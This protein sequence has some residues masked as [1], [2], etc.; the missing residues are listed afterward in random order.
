MILHRLCPVRPLS[1]DRSAAADLSDPDDG[2]VGEAIASRDVGD[3]GELRVDDAEG[4][5]GPEIAQAPRGMPS[6]SRPSPDEVAKHFLT[7]LPYRSWCKWCVAAKRANSAHVAL[8]GHSREVPLLVADYC[9]LRDSR[10]DDLLTC[11]VARLYP[12]RA[13]LAV[14]CDVKG[15]DDY[16]VNRLTEFL[17]NA[18]ITRMV[19]MSDQETA[20]GAM[21]EASIGQLRGA[22]T[23]AG[24]VRETSAVG[25]SQSNGKAEAAVKAVED[26]VRV[27]KGALESRINVRIPSQHPVMKWMVQY[28]GV[29]L[30]KYAIQPDGKTA[31]HALHGR[32]ASERIVEF[33]ECVM[34][35]VPKKRRSKLDQ[36]WT[37]GIFLGTTMH[38]NEC[39]VALANG[40][41]VRGRAITRVR[42]DQRW[43]R[44]AVQ[45]VRGTPSEPLSKDDTEVETFANPHDHD[46]EAEGE[47]IGDEDAEKSRAGLRKRIT[48]ADMDKYGYSPNCPRCRAHRTKNPRYNN[49]NHTEVCRARFYKMM[50]GEQERPHVVVPEA[51]DVLDNLD[52]MDRATPEAAVPSEMPKDDFAGFPDLMGFDDEPDMEEPDFDVIDQAVIDEM[53][54]E[55]EERE[56]DRSQ[57]S[58]DVDL[59]LR[60]G[61]EPVDACRLATKPLRHDI[62]AV[63]FIEAY[64][65]GGLMNEAVKCP[66]GIK[67]LNALDFACLKPDGTRWDFTL[68]QNRH[69]AMALVDAQDPDWI[70]G[71]PPCTSFSLLNRGLN[72]PKMDQ[73]IVAR[74]IAEGMIHLKFVCALYRRQARRGKWFLHEHPKTAA[75]WHTLP[76][77]RILKMPDVGTSTMDQCMYGLTTPGTN[78]EPVPAKKPTRWMS[79]SPEMLEMLCR[80]CDK[81]H[82]HQHLVGGRAAAASFYPPQLLR[83]ILQGMAMTRDRAKSVKMIHDSRSDVL[84]GF[85][86]YV[87]AMNRSNQDEPNDNNSAGTEK[88]NSSIPLAAGGEHPIQYDTHNFKA[89][90][91]DEYTGEELPNHLVRA[92]M[93][94]ELN[95]FNAHVWDATDKKKAESLDGYKLIRMRWVI[96]NKGD[97]KDFDVR[98]R[99]VA[100]E[101]NTYKTDEY[102]ASTPPLE[103]KRLLFSEFAHKARHPKHKKRNMVL[104]FVDVKKA[105]FNGIPRRN[106]HLVFPKELGMPGHLVAHLKR[107]V[108]GTRDAGAIWEDCYADALVELGF[109]RGIANPCCFYHVERDIMVVVHGD[110]FTALGGHDDIMWYED[111]LATKFEIKRRGHL[112]E[113]PGCVKE[114]R[115][116]NRIVRLTQDG[117]R[118]K[119]DPRHAE[120][121]IKA[122]DLVSSNALSTPGVKEPNEQTSYDAQLVHED[123]AHATVIA[124][125]D[126][127][128]I[129]S[130]MDMPMV[131]RSVHFAESPADVHEITPYSEIY[132]VH[133]RSI[134]A[135]RI[136]WLLVSDSANPYTG[137][138]KRVMTKRRVEIRDD[139]RPQLIDLERR[140]AINAM[141]WYGFSWE[142]CNGRRDL[143]SGRGPIREVDGHSG[144]HE[145]ELRSDE[146]TA[147][148]APEP[149]LV[150]ESFANPRRPVHAVRTPSS[151]NKFQ[152]RQGARAIK[153]IEMEGNREDLLDADQATTYR[154]MSARGNYL[155]QD[156]VD[157]SFCTKE[158]CREFAAPANSSLQRL[159]RLARF[160]V[161]APRLVYKYDWAH[162][163][164]DN[165]LTV[166]VDTDFA[167]CRVSRRSTNG[168]VIMRGNHCL[169]H[170]SSTQTTVALSSGEAELGGLCKGAANGIGMRSV[171]KDLGVAFKIK[172]LSDA[173]AA[174][175]MC[176]RLGVGKVRHLDTSL[177]WIQ[178]KVREGEISVGKILGTDNPADVLT[179]HVDAASMKKHLATMGLE[180]EDGRAESAPEL[181]GQ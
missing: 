160:L 88:A 175:G 127:T 17:R 166:I 153:K 126:G 75:S 112:G 29:L 177:L 100:C 63:T 18:G 119:A 23:W 51:A 11:L 8:P 93:E 20:L 167:G 155:A 156:R 74:K 149:T 58:M 19:H 89:I 138:S 16:A 33:G 94:E 21:I 71:S 24:S 84:A 129:A 117:L 139:S 41:V 174:L 50:E 15:P 2:F 179:K 28:A 73:A 140:N 164:P 85:K 154:G 105:Y 150:P 107:C 134:I 6:P 5:A 79:N 69:D 118:Y 115:I 61:C 25:E 47:V 86:T 165:E 144:L 131:N 56:D 43:D 108:Y 163:C 7:H 42:P 66:L 145:S 123:D 48:I 80:Q 148:L 81:S 106:L 60:L 55:E 27:M 34:H 59:L 72:Y 159:K 147:A 181:V 172:M 110:D 114:M 111:L 91:K 40:S 87:H 151:K 125:E 99:L 49:Y 30:N 137:K 124:D 37:L 162:D 9:Y 31:Y 104:S 109:R 64:G 78:R 101:V 10:D 170:W 97:Q 38:S 168:G 146:T 67:G 158:L 121:L 96:C 180:Y 44:D 113:G 46:V 102:F 77:K 3:D 22:T 92:A 116:L 171:A 4:A 82:A 130:V 12:S 90:Y 32:K 98:A 122:M 95:Y 136:G 52:G 161:G 143:G 35:Y 141:H 65:R 26:Q 169:R 128:D 14:P 57:F 133:P 173:T 178:A 152:K 176:R 83:A 54:R 62:H 76:I 53:L 36:R 103:A 1:D 13:V 68:A 120:M 70:I 157:I 132:G 142:S 135:T 45:K 39:Y